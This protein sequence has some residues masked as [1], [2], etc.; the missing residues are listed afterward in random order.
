[1]LIGMQYV[2]IVLEQEVGDGGDQALFIR[3]GDQKDGGVAHDIAEFR[4]NGAF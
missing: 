2:G 4:V 3:A 1:M